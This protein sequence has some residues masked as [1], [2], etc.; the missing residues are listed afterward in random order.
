[1]LAPDN[2]DGHGAE[3]GAVD[4]EGG[5]IG[6][7]L[8]DRDARRE[9]GR[10]DGSL[11]ATRVVDIQRVDARERGALGGEV[12][13]G[14]GRQEGMAVE[15]GVGAPVAVPPGAD[16]YRLAAVE[17]AVEVGAGVRAEFDR[18]DLEFRALAP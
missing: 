17:R 13:C 18:A 14:G 7:V 11:A 2:L 6:E 9:Q 8:A 10:V 3:A 4:R 5:K 16:E 1:M 15:V 12:V